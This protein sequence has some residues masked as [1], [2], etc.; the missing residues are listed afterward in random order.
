MNYV[1]ILRCRNGS[2]YTGWTNDLEAR[3]KAHCSGRGAKYTKM[4]PP[5]CIAYYETY[6]N[7][8]DA[9]SR[10]V[11]IKNLTRK[12]KEELIEGI[13][14]VNNGHMGDNEI[15]RNIK[16]EELKIY[17]CQHCG[18]VIVKLHDSKVPVACCSEEMKLLQANTVDASKEKHVPVVT[19]SEGGRIKVSV[20]AAAH[21]MT[22]EHYIEFIILQ[23]ANGYR[24]ANLN[25]GDKPEVEF[26]EDEPVVA[27]YAYCNIH[28]LW[29]TEA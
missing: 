19:R 18:N 8:K 7:K 12:E 11:Y 3:Y 13:K 2:C 16:M 15:R 6:Q 17:Y 24:V 28:G 5:V 10:E 25:P 26:Y 1:Y 27:V 9:L 22:P 23:T 20:G 4:H 14:I 21:P 29:K